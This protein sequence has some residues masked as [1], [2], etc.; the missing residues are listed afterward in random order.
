[1][2]TDDDM[3]E[4]EFLEMPE[5]ALPG[6]LSRLWAIRSNLLHQREADE[7]SRELAG[8]APARMIFPWTDPHERRRIEEK[9]R[10][11]QLAYEEEMIENEQRRDRL[12]RRIDEEQAEI[13]ERRREIE[14]NALRL[15]DGRRAYIDG[16]RYR[17]GE[18]RVLTGADEAE[19]AR[20]HE[21]R[22]DASTWAEKQEID[23]RAE[24]NQ[25]LKDKILKDRE[26]GQGTPEQ[27]AQ[28]L[29]GFE[30]EFAEKVQEREGEMDAAATG[31]SNAQTVT[32]YG[33]ADYMNAFD[34]DS[35]ISAVPAF[36]A[37]A[38]N[39]L[40]ETT[41]KL[42]DDDSGAQAAEIKKPSQPL[43]KP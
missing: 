28:R 23:R 42:S 9:R 35:Q 39:V 21:Y 31:G 7:L 15:R 3:P 24:E 12:L 17:D 2:D 20:Q 4:D 25:K 22:P 26:D 6:D 10:R 38:S 34:G 37:A 41:R 11:E 33:S 19:A 40:P 8:D 14:N 30:K 18:G 36:T 27:A 1:M 13:D 29:D 5:Q 43:F 16:D 32:G